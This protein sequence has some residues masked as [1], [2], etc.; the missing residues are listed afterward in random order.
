MSIAGPLERVA[1]LLFRSAAF[2]RLKHA[3]AGKELC[4]TRIHQVPRS[5]HNAEGIFAQSKGVFLL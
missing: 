2:F 1:Y 5:I 3:Q 4:E